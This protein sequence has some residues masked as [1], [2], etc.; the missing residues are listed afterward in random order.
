MNLEISVMDT[1]EGW[2]EENLTENFT[3]E[4]FNLSVSD[5]RP[6]TV[7]KG[8][9]LNWRV[10]GNLYSA[11]YGFS[12]GSEPAN[13][14]ASISYKNK[15]GNVMARAESF[16]GAGEF[17]EER[18]AYTGEKFILDHKPP[19]YIV[20]YNAADRLVKAGNTGAEH[21]KKESQPEAGYTAYY[22]KNIEVM[23]TVEE[24]YAAAFEQGKDSCFGLRILWDGREMEEVPDISWT[25][26]GNIHTGTF[27]LA[28]EGSYEVF[29]CLLYTSPSPRDP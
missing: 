3:L 21:D 29:L 23:L 12:G 18:G 25:H 22:K 11:A 1:P 7:V 13:Y 2:S 4:I 15:L 28:E 9:E 10:H 8:N 20:S 17:D 16:Q 26:Q 14:K 6:S 5:S 27:R 19:Y 24:D